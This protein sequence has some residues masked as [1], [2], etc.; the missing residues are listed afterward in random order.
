M[1]SEVK[2]ELKVKDIG[3]VATTKMLSQVIDFANLD[4]MPLTN[5]EKQY[6]VGIIT[7]INKKIST[8]DKDGRRVEWQDLDVKGY[9]NKSKAMQN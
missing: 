7:N 9:L 1:N 2:N 4:S 6:A 5:V 3:Q 8:P